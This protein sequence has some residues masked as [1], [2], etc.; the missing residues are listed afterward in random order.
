MPI[1]NA[2]AGFHDEILT[3]LLVAVRNISRSLV[4]VEN[5]LELLQ[6][7]LPQR[8]EQPLRLLSPPGE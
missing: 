7:G 8:P 6:E 2:P 1:E 5:A 3:Q 4:H